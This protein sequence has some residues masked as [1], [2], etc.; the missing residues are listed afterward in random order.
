MTCPF[1]KFLTIYCGPREPL[2]RHLHA[3]RDCQAVAAGSLAATSGD[4]TSDCVDVE[5]LFAYRDD[6]LGADDPSDQKRAAHIAECGYCQRRLLELSREDADMAASSEALREGDAYMLARDLARW[7]STE[8]YP[9]EKDAVDQ[10]F[11]PMFLAASN[12]LRAGGRRRKDSGLTVM[13]RLG[14]TGAQGRGLAQSI[15]EV[16]ALVA[17]LR[18]V[19]AEDPAQVACLLDESGKDLLMAGYSEDLLAET[20]ARLRS[21]E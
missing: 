19:R 2:E 6:M 16:A 12:R 15:I 9:R 17:Y 1:S 14:F 7:L 18:S 13:I 11:E 21:M 20:L 8:A 10:Q 4:E 5:Y 3:C